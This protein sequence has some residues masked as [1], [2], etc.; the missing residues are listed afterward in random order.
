MTRRRSWSAVLAALVFGAS[1]LLIGYLL[2]PLPPV[3]LPAATR[4]YAADGRLLTRLGIQDRVPVPLDE[5]PLHLRQAVIAVEDRRFYRHFGLDPIGIVRAAWRNLTAGELVEG[6]STLTQQLARTLYL[7]QDRTLA[8]KLREALL[9]LKIETHWSKDE[10]LERYLSAIY[11]GHGAWGM[12]VAAQTYFGKSVRQVNLAEAAM[13]AGIIG[14]PEHFSPHRNRSLAERRQA[15]VLERM[16]EEGF[17]T[18][19][20]AQAARAVPLQLA[21]PPATRATAPYFIDYVRHV[22]SRELP[23]VAADLD[24]GGYRIYTTIDPEL[25]RAA[26]QR[27]REG[28]GEPTRRDAHGVPQPQGALVAL[29]PRTGY[30]RALVG[31]R[32]YSESS[33]N[34]AYRAR[35][36]PG[37]AFKVFVYTAALDRGIPPTATQV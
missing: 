37:S 32:D 30:I 20:Q 7:S 18:A 1:G 36:Q 19:V 12:E 11:M 28:L 27:L 23:A 21:E 2:A 25:Q 16:V 34:R 29:D 26:E 4:V 9:A 10:I 31:G 17:I 24:R 13:L 35:R 14:S 33:F 5:V 6:G 3:D 8:R 22:L 15:L